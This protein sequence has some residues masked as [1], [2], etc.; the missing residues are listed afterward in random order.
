MEF[1]EYASQF[2][3]EA[4]L[5]TINFILCWAMDI[6]NSDIPAASWYYV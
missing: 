5:Q 6:Q 3:I 1:I 2:L 4:A